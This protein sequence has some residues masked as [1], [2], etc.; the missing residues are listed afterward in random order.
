MLQV[1]S[2][3]KRFGNINTMV[4]THLP[5]AVFLAFDTDDGR[6]LRLSALLD[7]ALLH[8]VHGWPTQ[9]RFPCRHFAPQRKNGRHG[10]AQCGQEYGSEFEPNAY[11]SAS[12]LRFYLRGR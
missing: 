2:L 6:R 8:A 7:P 4:F 3:A 12:G 5:S 10:M 11:W 1:S 9:I